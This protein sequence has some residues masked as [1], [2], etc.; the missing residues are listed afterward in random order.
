M[1]DF[2]NDI[3]R[4]ATNLAFWIALLALLGCTWSVH[5]SFKGSRAEIDKALDDLYEA[6]DRLAETQRPSVHA[7]SAPLSPSDNVVDIPT[8]QTAVA[9]TDEAV[10]GLKA[11]IGLPTDPHKIPHQPA[12]DTTEL[13][14]PAPSTIGSNLTDTDWAYVLHP[15]HHLERIDG[16]TIPAFR[17]P[18][19][20]PTP[21][22]LAAPTNPGFDA[23]PTINLN[24]ATRLTHAGGR[25]R[26]PEDHP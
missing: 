22:Q 13:A 19:D 11:T 1:A 3:P 9:R 17:D 25:H 16:H 10:E 15:N 7:L 21:D 4:W 24:G 23:P 26:H 14:L 20:T 2:L 5:R 18:D 6:L 8:A 12:A